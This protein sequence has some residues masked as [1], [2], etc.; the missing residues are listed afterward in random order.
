MNPGLKGISKRMK[1]T[2][3]GLLSVAQFNAFFPNF[4]KSELENGVFA[5]IQTAH[6]AEILIKACIAEKDPLL[7]F[8][9]LPQ[10]NQDNS[11]L[12]FDTLF[13]SGKTLQYNELP[14]KLLAITGYNIKELSL[15][16]SFG[17]LR[18]GI[19]HFAVPKGDLS[20]KAIEYIY[21]VIDP[22]L[23]H[24]WGLYAVEYCSEDV[25]TYLP[26]LMDMEIA[27]RYPKKMK[28]DIDE[29]ISWRETNK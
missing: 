14:K 16:N 1:K 11:S 29:V 20:P 28:A 3:L 27:F 6:A 21:K 10:S 9:Q 19:Q 12:D 8:S 25:F 23:E 5:V 26:I 17:K 13:E 15:F 2:G 18:N 22:I 24:F 7:I 4:D